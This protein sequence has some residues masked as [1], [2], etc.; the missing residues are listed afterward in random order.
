MGR[1]VG[2]ILIVLA[3]AGRVAADPGSEAV[4]R[5]I[6]YIQVDTTN[7]PGNEVRGAE[8]FAR[9]FDAAGI[10]YE[11]VESA[12]GR[13]NIW[14][15]LEGG[16]EP[17]LVLLNHMDVVPADPGYWSV[18]PLSGTVRDGYIYGRGARDMK[19]TAIVQLQ[20]FLAL[21]ASGARLDRDVVF[22]ATA[23]EEAGGTLGAGWVAE[24]RPELF[25]DVGYLLNEGG[26]GTRYG[27]QT[28]FSVEVTQKVPL[29]LRIT[30]TGEP[31]HGS[32]W[33]RDTAVSRL[34]RAASR[35]AETEQPVRVIDPVAAAFAGVAPYQNAAFAAGF[36][37]IRTASAE[38]DFMRLL[39]LQAPWNHALLRDTC[40]VTRLA[41]SSK[42]NVIPP[43]AFA[44]VDC[45]LLPDRDPAEFVQELGILIGDPDVSIE[46]L[47]SFSPAVS[48]IDTPLFEAIETVAAAEIPG[49]VTIPGVSTGFT[50]S[51]F[52]R[53]LGIVS[54]GFSPFVSPFGED[55]GVHGNDERISIENVEM[56][57]RFMVE[58]VRRFA[59]E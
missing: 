6:D 52:F 53:D 21:H 40:S 58:L 51:H 36:A 1:T 27:T 22:M 13:G 7:P 43:E 5:L 10:D 20:A 41:A 17:G 49:A 24:H 11:I 32:R 33:R 45:R 19:G 15:R 47:L 42:I 12:P 57:T 18:P 31:G 29:W 37:D 50:D 8:F 54:Y 30:A 39:E 16:P 4:A 23:D 46:V 3:A 34:L 55:S 28:V 25:E 2:V 35:I 26:L 56:G 38:R 9:I 48:G 44:E 59:T 14:A